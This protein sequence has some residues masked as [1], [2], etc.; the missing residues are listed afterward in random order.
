MSIVLPFAE[1]FLVEEVSRDV[2]IPKSIATTG[3]CIYFRKYTAVYLEA[4]ETRNE[5]PSWIGGI[6]RVIPT[7]C[8]VPTS[9]PEKRLMCRLKLRTG[10]INCEI[11]KT[12]FHRELRYPAN[13]VCCCVHT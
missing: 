5:D 3:I 11:D 4:L 13:I 8:N 10:K 1:T 9:K 7:Y 2:L 12:C 6:T